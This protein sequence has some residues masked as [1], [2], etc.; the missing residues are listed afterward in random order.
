MKPIETWLTENFERRQES[1]AGSCIT[2]EY[3]AKSAT[4]PPCPKKPSAIGSLFAIS[5]LGS[6]FC[7]SLCVG[8]S[9]AMAL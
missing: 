7:A 4:T 6:I 8:M 5:L 1:M 9:L 3:V 2:V